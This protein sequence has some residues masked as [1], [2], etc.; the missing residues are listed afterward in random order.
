[1]AMTQTS[2]QISGDYFEN[3][4]CDVVCPCLI[5]PQGPFAARPTQG[6]CDLAF[7][8]HIDRGAFGDVSLDGLN[9]AAIGQTPGAMGLGNVSLAV[10]LDQRADD[11]QREALQ[12]ILDG[13]TGGPMGALAPLVS[14]VLGVKSVPIAYTKEGRRRAVEIPDVMH[15]AVQAVPSLIPDQE[16]WA[17]TGHPFNPDKLAFAV[18]EA[19]STFQDYGMRWDNSGKNGHYAS[20]NWSNG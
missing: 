15:M 16:S 8:L 3:C 10:Y 14:N 12:K 2:W 9:A 7:A 13:S 19:D 17:A 20:I 4:N 5:A 11:R 1:M 6:H 18:G